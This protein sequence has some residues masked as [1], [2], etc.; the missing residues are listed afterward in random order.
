[1]IAILIFLHMRP[2]WNSSIHFNFNFNYFLLKKV[3]VY[4]WILSAD[5]R[6]LDTLKNLFSMVVFQGSHITSIIFEVKEWLS[7]V[8]RGLFCVNIRCM[9]N[10]LISHWQLKL[11][12]LRI[13]SIQL[14][15]RL[16]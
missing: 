8:I 12:I 16:C 9:H 1:M 15:R 10:K 11:C 3:H 2:P 7:S 6:S 14:A 5:M 4:T 13:L